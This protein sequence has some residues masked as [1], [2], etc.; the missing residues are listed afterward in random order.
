MVAWLPCC[1]ICNSLTGT[2]E[3]ISNGHRLL[4]WL[5][6]IVTNHDRHLR[7]FCDNTINSCETLVYLANTC[8][9]VNPTRDLTKKSSKSFESHSVL[10]ELTYFGSN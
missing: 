1:L 4:N 9:Y 2:F 3:N 5:E 7:Q 10:R 8:L 6:I